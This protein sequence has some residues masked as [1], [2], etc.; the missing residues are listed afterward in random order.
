MGDDDGVLAGQLVDGRSDAC[1]E[2]G[3][4]LGVRRGELPPLPGGDV[5]G[6]E[7][8][9]RAARPVADVDLAPARIG[10]RAVDPERDRGLDRT[11]EVGGQRARRQVLEVRPQR[12]GLLEAEWRQRRVGLSLEPVLGVP[13]RLAVADEEEAAQ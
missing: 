7:L 10:R 12:G 8:V 6:I 2:L 4:R 1:L 9:E 3:E 11:R 13:G 5:A